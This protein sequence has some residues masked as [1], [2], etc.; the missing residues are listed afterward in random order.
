MATY[1]EVILKSI[2][3]HCRLQRQELA[4]Q[5]LEGGCEDMFQY[6]ECVGKGMAYAEVI[7]HIEEKTRKLLHDEDDTDF[8]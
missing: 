6:R 1:Y 7:E 8:Q 3:E 2:K 5:M 4:L